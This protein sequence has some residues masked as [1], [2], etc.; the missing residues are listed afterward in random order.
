MPAE[1]AAYAAALFAELHRLDAQSFDWIAI[2][3]PPD[4]PEWAGV[5]DRL[6]RAAG[7]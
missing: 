3:L 7:P 1:P 6:K 4:A 2:E 5:R